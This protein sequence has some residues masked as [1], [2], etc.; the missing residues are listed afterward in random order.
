MDNL[1]A[2][3][4]AITLMEFKEHFNKSEVSRIVD[5]DSECS[6]MARKLSEELNEKLVGTDYAVSVSDFGSIEYRKCTDRKDGYT[7]WSVL[8]TQYSPA[9]E[10]LPYEYVMGRKVGKK[11]MEEVVREIEQKCELV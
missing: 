3:L 9:H 10:L 5:F 4:N 8:S 6:K 2:R 7:T 1:T 11:K